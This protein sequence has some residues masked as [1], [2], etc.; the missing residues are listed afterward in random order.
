MNEIGAKEV[1]TGAGDFVTSL[2]L[3]I[4]VI[5]H[6]IYDNFVFIKLASATTCL[7]LLVGIVILI[8]K[9]SYFEE[10]SDHYF[11]DS[12]GKAGLGE[13]RAI[14]HWKGVVKKYH[15]GSI[16]HIKL[17]LGEADD[18][19]DEILKARAFPGQGIDERLGYISEEQI[20]GIN[21]LIKAHTLAKS[22]REDPA[23]ETT[24]ELL[25]EALHSYQATL[26][27]LKI[28]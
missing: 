12:K 25:S 24:K 22:L 20:P 3:N 10:T 11:F 19:L 23:M 14:R 13:E 5:G 15:S 6:L 7:I 1:L 27:E 4:P 26:E 2:I 8:I 16:E 28:L 17:A 18:I 21:E 9:N